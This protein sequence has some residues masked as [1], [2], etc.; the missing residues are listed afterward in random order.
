MFK[1]EKISLIKINNNKAS[2]KLMDKDGGIV[3]LIFIKNDQIIIRSGFD[4][5]ETTIESPEINIL[6]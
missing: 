6:G 1:D 2:I 3:C 4:V 5:G